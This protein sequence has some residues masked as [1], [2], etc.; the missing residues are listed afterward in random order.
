MHFHSS[1]LEIAVNQGLFGY[2]IFAF[3]LYK[4]FAYYRAKYVLREPDGDFLPAIVFLLFLLQIDTFVYMAGLGFI[5]FA[6]LLAR[7]CVPQP[8]AKRVDSRVEEGALSMTA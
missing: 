4:L 8:V 6:L 5:I 3:L 2:L 1:S 7:V